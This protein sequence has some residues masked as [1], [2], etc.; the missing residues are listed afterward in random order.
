MIRDDVVDV[1]LGMDVPASVLEDFP[2]LPS[3]V[4]GLLVYGSQARRDAVPGSDLDM[5]ALVTAQRPSAESGY[6]HVSYYTR[7]QLSTG[8]GTLFGAHL[9]RDAKIVWDKHGHLTQAVEDMGEVDTKRLLARARSLS[10]LFTTLDRDLPK[11]LSGLLRQARYLLRSCL[12]AQAIADSAPCFSVRELA[13]RHGDPHLTRLLAS[14]Q[15]GEATAAD[16]EQ[17]LS[18][19]RRIIGDFPPSKHGSLE[20]TVVNEWGRPSDILSMAFMALGVTGKTSDYAEVEKIL[21]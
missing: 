1:L 11:Y 7:K 19:L 10:E 8:I 15:P 5:L 12:Y 18:R 3:D 20:A 2:E 16:L 21:L 4:E 14:W 17:C 9:K 6:V 13:V